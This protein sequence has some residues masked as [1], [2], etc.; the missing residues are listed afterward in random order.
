MHDVFFCFVL[1]K[2]EAKLPLYAFKRVDN[3]EGKDL[4]LFA[5]KE[6]PVAFLDSLALGEVVMG[7]FI[8]GG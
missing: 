5:C 7:F 8:V 4:H 3:A 6:Q 1:L 2:T